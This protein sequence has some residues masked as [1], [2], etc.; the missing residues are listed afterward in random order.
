MCVGQC[1]RPL[2]SAGWAALVSV[3]LS[4]ACFSR[5]SW[6]V[7]ARRRLGSKAQLGVCGYERRIVC[8]TGKSTACQIDRQA[9]RQMRTAV[10]DGWS[11]H[12]IDAC[13]V[14]TLA[15][16]GA[17]RRCMWSTFAVVGAWRQRMWGV[18]VD[19]CCSQAFGTVGALETAYF[20]ATGKQLLLSEQQLVDCTVRR[21]LNHWYRMA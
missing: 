2:L 9:D 12:A 4:S 17:W 8:Y 14:S 10:S 21:T 20:S 16:V 5:V 19:R 11:A 18:D 7:R 15:V 6:P 1:C 13:G 3:Y